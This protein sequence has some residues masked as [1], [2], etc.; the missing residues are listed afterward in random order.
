[1]YNRIV[2]QLEA[3]GCHSPLFIRKSPDHHTASPLFTIFGKET[4]THPLYHIWSDSSQMSPRGVTT[5]QGA[6]QFQ[7]YGKTQ[8]TQRR[9]SK[10]RRE[11]RKFKVTRL[12]SLLNSLSGRSPRPICVCFRP[13]IISSVINCGFLHFPSSLHLCLQPT[14]DISG[15]V[16]LSSTG[17]LF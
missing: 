15:F 14:A 11:N 10:R 4:Q 1:M 3:S 7:Q 8:Y 12:I 2:E 6:Q 17:S 13:F 16:F 5:S 9:L